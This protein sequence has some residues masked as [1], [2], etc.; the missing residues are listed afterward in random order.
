[1]GEVVHVQ[2]SILFA[3]ELNERFDPARVKHY[4]GERTTTSEDGQE[5]SEW[6]VDMADIRRFV[7]EA[8]L[9]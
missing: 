1:M 8:R 5:I 9:S 4:L 6:L 7:S 3:D 2:N